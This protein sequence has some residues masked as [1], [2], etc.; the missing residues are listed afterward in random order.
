MGNIGIKV[1]FYGNIKPMFWNSRLG[2]DFAPAAFS[3]SKLDISLRE[4][5]FGGD[6]RMLSLLR[7]VLLCPQ[8]MWLGLQLP[9]FLGPGVW[10]LV[11]P[12]LL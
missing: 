9:G 7:I 6:A 8:C 12:S 5:F 10:F 4:I 2:G 1:Q 3:F 11:T